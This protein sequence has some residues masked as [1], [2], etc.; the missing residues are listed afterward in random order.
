[1]SIKSSTYGATL[2]DISGSGGPI[3]AINDI[4]A[5]SAAILTIATGSTTYLSIDSAGT[6]TSSIATNALYYGILTST[7]STN[8]NDYSPAGWDSSN[9]NKKTVI[10]ISGST[11][12]KITGLTGG[13]DGRVCIIKNASSDFLVILEDQSASSQAANRFDFRNPIFLIPNGSVTI[14]YDGVSSRW[15]PMGSSGGIGYGAFFDDYEDFLGDSG[16]W[17]VVASGT[18]ASSQIST[19]LQNTTE[20]PIGIWQSDTGTTATGRAY[21]G[22][23]QASSIYP[24]YGQA[25]CLSRIAVEQLSTAAQRFHAYS[26]WT[27]ASGFASSSNGL[28]WRYSDQYATTWQ[29]VAQSSSAVVSSSVNGPTTDTNYIWLGIYNNSTWT[30]STFFYSTDSITWT[31]AGVISGSNMPASA[32]TTGFGM[33]INKTIGTTQCNISVDVLAH[34]YDITRG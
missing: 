10:N 14:I 26:G 15:E 11:S 20:R 9:P 18:G 7:P 34:R 17:G 22:S 1:M 24:G 23:T 32:S 4:T 3:I 5:S 21:V 33:G 28:F 29:G 13:V 19:Y 30:R 31:I 2:L 6:T 16:K 8:Q 27:N 25:I 12:V